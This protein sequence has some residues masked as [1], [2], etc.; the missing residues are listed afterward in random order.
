MKIYNNFLKNNPLERFKNVVTF[1][2]AGLYNG[3]KQLKP[4]NPILGETFQV[5]K[6]NILLY[7]IINFNIKTGI[8][9][10]WN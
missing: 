6:K 4:F 2:M 10:R 8:L 5:F 9:A 3:C 7:I 1:A